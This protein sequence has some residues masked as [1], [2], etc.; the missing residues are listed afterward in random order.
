MFK[1]RKQNKLLNMFIS[2]LL[3]FSI[4]NTCFANVFAL[5]SGTITVQLREYRDG[6]VTDVSIP[7]AKFELRKLND[8]SFSLENVTDTTGNCIFSGL[9]DG[10]YEIIQ[11]TTSE[12]Y[13]LPNTNTTVK[14]ASGNNN[15]TV[16]VSNVKHNSTTDVNIDKGGRT[17]TTL[18]LKVRSNF[19]G[20]TPV[21]G[22]SF[23]V[24]SVNGVR[25]EITTNS[26]GIATL[27]GLT[28]GNYTITQISSP[29]GFMASPNE[30]NFEIP[31]PNIKGYAEYANVTF[32]NEPYDVNTYGKLYI[33]V[34]DKNDNSKVIPN[35][36][37]L[38]T[39]DLGNSF[40][41]STDSNG[42]I[43]FKN[44]SK[45]RTYSAKIIESPYDYEY[46]GANVEG[47]IKL[48]QLTNNKTISM[49]LPKK[50]TNLVTIVNHEA[51]DLSVRISGSRFRLIHPDGSSREF[52]ISNSNGML[53]MQLPLSTDRDYI[54]EQL[55][56]DGR[57]KISNKINFSIG[58]PVTIYVPNNLIN[59]NEEKVS[60]SF[61]KEWV[62]KP[63]SNQ[64]VIVRLMQNGNVY[65]NGQHYT[66]YSNDGTQTKKFADLPKYDSQHIAYNYSVKEDAVEG[67]Y[68]EYQEV[69][70]NN[71]K[72]SNY[73][74]SM[75]GQCM[76]DPSKGV[77]WFSGENS[78]FMM[79]NG[80]D[81]KKQ[82]N[83]PT[84]LDPTFGYGIAYDRTKGY[85]FGANRRGELAIMDPTR[86]ENGA[87][88]NVVSLGGL[89]E[90][91]GDGSDESGKFI[92][93]NGQNIFVHKDFRKLNSLET[94]VDG[95]YLFA[96][97]LADP[98]IYMYRISDI[99]S[100]NVGYGG[101]V[102]PARI[103]HARHIVNS[104]INANTPVSDGDII[105]YPN[106]D[107]LYSG[108]GNLFYRG[109]L[110][111]PMRDDFNFYLLKYD[112]PLDSNG[113]VIDAGQGS[114]SEPINVG[115]LRVPGEFNSFWDANNRD[116]SIEGMT[117]AFGQIWFTS[118]IKDKS[119]G[120]ITKRL[121]RIVSSQ[122]NKGNLPN[123]Y[124][125]GVKFEAQ[126]FEGAN[127]TKIQELPTATFADMTGGDREICSPEVVVRGAKTWVGDDEGT[128][129]K[130]I[131]VQLYANGSPYV[132]QNGNSSRLT[133][134]DDNNWKYQFSQLPKYDSSNRKIDYS[135]K[136]IDPPAGYISTTTDYSI[137]NTLVRGGFYIKKMNENKSLSLGGAKF[138]LLNESKDT[139]IQ[140]STETD[141][142]GIASFNNLTAGTYYLREEVAP[143]SYE[144]DAQ[145]YRVVGTLNQST[146]K[147]EFEVFKGNERVDMLS[148]KHVI[149]NSKPKFNIKIVKIDSKT[150]RKITVTSRF[151]IVDSN[152][153]TING[154]V[155]NLNNG[156]FIFNNGGNKFE[157]G[158]YYIKEVTPP[159]GYKLVNSLI[160]ITISNDGKV[161]I[162]TSDD[163]IVDAYGMNVTG[164]N[165]VEIKIKNEKIMSRLVFSKRIK[166]IEETGTHGIT[167]KV[168]FKLT[169]DN[170]AS[171]SA[172]EIEKR[173]NE[174]FV[175]ENLTEGVYTLEETKAPNGYVV[176]T[177]SYKVVVDGVGKVYLYSKS[178]SE[179]SKN[180]T[181][182]DI[183]K[184]PDLS[185][186]TSGSIADALDGNDATA[187]VFHNF[188]NQG[189]DIP[190]GSYVGVDLRRLYDIKSISFLQGAPGNDADRFNKF[191]LEYSSDGTNWKEYKNYIETDTTKGVTKPVNNVNEANL[192]LLAR[193]IRFKNNEVRQDVWFGVKEIKVKGL[194]YKLI[195]EMTP[196]M[197]KQ[198][199]EDN[200]A[201]IGNIQNP[202]IVLEKI[203]AETST[204]ISNN[205]AGLSYNAR[206]KL[207]KVGDNITSVSEND[208]KT[209]SPV[210]EFTLNSGRVELTQLANKLGRYALVE[211]ESPTGYKKTEPILLDLV[212]TQQVHSMP[213]MKNTTAWKVVGNT[214]GSTIGESGGYTTFT[215]VA[216]NE[217]IIV[218]YTNLSGNKITLK[219]KN[220]RQDRPIRL[221]IRKVDE[222]GMPIA[223]SNYEDI[224]RFSILDSDKRM[225]NNQVANLVGGEFTFDNGG[226]K[227][228]AGLYHLK[229]ERAPKGYLLINTEIPFYIKDSGDVI[230]PA[231]LKDG[232][233][234]EYE[235]DEQFAYKNHLKV[236]QSADTD[237]VEIS[238]ENKK[239]VFPYT[240]GIGTLLYLSTGILLMGTAVMSMKLRR[241]SKN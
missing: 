152:G 219:V 210:Q 214:T 102:Q 49:Y 84:Y 124:T 14:L 130:S 128:R 50:Q 71:W 60:F 118:V 44:F 178:N 28:Y 137:T 126:K 190:V 235:V 97:V 208:L 189:N 106:G 203:D 197:Q 96:K 88:V 26:D 146:K 161:Y 4:L 192:N 76:I 195:K 24:T 159:N 180:I 194:E 222:K 53:E 65:G 16:V 175:F 100:N 155:A 75:T 117:Y 11:R 229:E 177:V 25:K 86:G 165:T 241:K 9:D 239:G 132:Y 140:S 104:S 150:G 41:R 145:E 223:G 163:G 57:H 108:H 113:R 181:N 201:L 1:K 12:T 220:D 10:E 82:I 151:A 138:S 185:N 184:S 224:S 46:S 136:E 147:I 33:N 6:T 2:L 171:F 156:E 122:P 142:D 202:S 103:I 79:E 78:A 232:S 94:S 240:G 179:T 209:I 125:G 95:K 34:Y 230:I 83:F 109:E 15:A 123:R 32:L 89:R 47:D 207:Y 227:F 168:K 157:A 17:S 218:D 105:Q 73:E 39:D 211:T 92:N 200:I 231:K 186:I 188:N 212:E 23:L 204:V 182:K 7:N 167:E 110:T 127:G 80:V 206:F 27:D 191:S 29:E 91:T 225:Y 45:D 61:T 162:N 143:E 135:V 101:V 107:I 121:A 129:P 198:D 35:V 3:V 234:S 20:E 43:T 164:T 54:L 166:G 13:K 72:I 216:I 38:I 74:G 51:G 99:L 111:A 115:S 40:V 213:K 131:E 59:P 172:V 144:R 22:A 205:N 217:K 85:L 66:L 176:D 233:N 98:N 183:I 158:T 31:K 37:L 19:D 170:D 68:A 193:Y 153:N 81:I 56:T 42:S 237:I 238:V 93:D 18:K 148:D 226:K 196:Q 63:S 169:K 133:L 112:G 139:I 114:Y 160:P 215:G 149:K 30:A 36:K 64:R 5:G 174:K 120:N 69:S 187:V 228:K 55:T 221:K 77:I 199:T 62:D 52:E 90:K 67:W 236:I 154:Q 48:D 21:V 87:V 58:R 116:T 70:K 8:P 134:N 173:F 119:T 141:S